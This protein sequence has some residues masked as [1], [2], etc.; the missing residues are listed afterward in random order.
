MIK[1]P[2]VE[3]LFEFNDTRKKAVFDGYRPAHLVTGNYLTT[4]I[5]HYYDVDSVNP[6]G[7]AKGTITFFLPKPIR[8]VCGSAKKSVFKR[9][10]A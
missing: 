2:D 5:H 10:N 6:N 7:I 8:I 9:E 1:L 4:G 3:V